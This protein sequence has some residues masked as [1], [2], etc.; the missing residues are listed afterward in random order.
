KV[1]PSE[2]GGNSAAA[3]RARGATSGTSGGNDQRAG[4]GSASDATG[5]MGVLSVRR[6][7]GASSVKLR[8]R[9][10]AGG[11]ETELSCD[12]VRVASASLGGAAGAVL[13][14]HAAT[15]RGSVAAAAAAAA[16]TTVGLRESRD[17]VG[18]RPFW[19]GGSKTETRGRA[20]CG[21]G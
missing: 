19:W 10:V 9:R 4:G 7:S 17:M 2:P 11:A 3:M 21:E 6:N 16:H 18:L 8:N 14:P 13:P 1:L 20:C 5:P 12:T 15:S